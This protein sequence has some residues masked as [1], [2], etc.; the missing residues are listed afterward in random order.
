[1]KIRVRVNEKD[2]EMEIQGSET[3]YDILKGLNIT[4]IRKS[5]DSGVCGLCTVLL[6]GKPIPSCSYLAAKAD[7]CSITTIEGIEEEAERFGK[8][9]NEEGAVQCAY[10]S[11]SFVLAVVSMKDNLKRFDDESINRYLAGNLCRCSGYQVHL[12]AIKRYLGVIE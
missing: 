6:N 7:G 4:S 5:C 12:R 1:M 3:V 9:M 8:L 2:M 11:P 10:C